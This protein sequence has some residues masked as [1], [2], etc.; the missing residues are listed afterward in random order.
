M[1]RV[2]EVLTKAP[3]WRRVDV[4]GADGIRWIGLN[5]S[6]TPLALQCERLSVIKELEGKISFN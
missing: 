3:R 2:L 6:P 4:G 1:V 5:P